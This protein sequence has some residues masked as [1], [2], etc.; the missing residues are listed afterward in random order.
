MARTRSVA[1]ILSSTTLTFVYRKNNP[2]TGHYFDNTNITAVTVEVRNLDNTAT[3][4][5]SSTAMTYDANIKGY[6]Y[7][8]TYGTNLTGV[9]SISVFF[10]PTISGISPALAPDEAIEIDLS[11]SDIRF[12]AASGI[13]NTVTTNGNFT[14]TSTD[15][16]VVDNAYNQ[17]LLVFTNGPNKFIPRRISI[18]TGITKTVAFTGDHVDAPFPSTVS[19]NDPFII[20]GIIA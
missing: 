5:L 17:M 16:V 4:L 9:H 15:L 11:T 19:P 8:W 18:Y 3:P 1:H 20:L 14:L 6:K 12:V 7:V 10:S 2:S 13:V